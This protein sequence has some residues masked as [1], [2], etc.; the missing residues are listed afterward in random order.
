MPPMMPPA[1]SKFTPQEW[2]KHV[3]TMDTSGKVDV[4]SAPAPAESPATTPEG[5]DQ[6]TCWAA[7]QYVLNDRSTKAYPSRGT[8]ISSGKTE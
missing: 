3:D 7:V 6:L 8:V 1:G 5:A 4:A 2:A